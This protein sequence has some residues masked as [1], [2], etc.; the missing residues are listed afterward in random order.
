MLL[1]D[2]SLVGFEP[3]SLV[4]LRCDVLQKIGDLE[5]EPQFVK[6]LAESSE[7]VNTEVSSSGDSPS[8]SAQAVAKSQ[9]NDGSDDSGSRS[10]RDALHL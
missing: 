2:E 7:R 10:I 8:P 3:P 9:A 1:D 5:G 4:S 6:G